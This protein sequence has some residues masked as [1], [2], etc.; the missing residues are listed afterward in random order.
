MEIKERVKAVIPVSDDAYKFFLADALREPL[1]RKA[2][3]F[4]D[5]PE[6]SCGL[7]AGCGIG[8]L[9]AMLAAKVGKKGHVTGIDLSSKHIK[10]ANDILRDFDAGKRITLKCADVRNLPFQDNTFDWLWSSDCA[11]Y[12]SESDPR[13]LLTGFKR[14]LK[15]GGLL[16]ILGWSAQTLLPGYPRL[17]AA[18]NSAA[19]YIAGV[20]Q[21]K[22]FL[23]ALAW[24]QDAGFE[25]GKGHLFSGTIQAPLSEIKKEAV[26][27][28]FDML[29]AGSSPGIS[30]EDWKV[31]RKISDPASTDFIL[32]DPGY[33]GFYSYVMFTA[34]KTT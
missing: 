32:D 34:R 16:A 3:D 2:I 24:F 13:S 21:G 11:G 17:E 10:Y 14:V 7:D 1:I 15:P 29:W 4:L 31:Y 5:L 20:K 26:L 27:A 25:N 9:T 30:R 33:F 23:N 18:L 22:Q 28:F 8:D 19:P 12:P 6:G